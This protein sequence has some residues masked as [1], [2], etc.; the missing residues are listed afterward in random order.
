MRVYKK[1]LSLLLGAGLLVAALGGCEPEGPVE[2]TEK[3][4]DETVENPGQATKEEE[5]TKRTGEEVG[6]TDEK[7][8]DALD[9]TTTP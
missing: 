2:Q 1:T 5:P 7:A 9:E 6:E 8:G 3:K 4:V